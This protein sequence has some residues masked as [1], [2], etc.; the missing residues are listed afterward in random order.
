[1]VAG[2]NDELAAEP[3]IRKLVEKLNTQKN[4]SVD[5][6]VF[7]GADHIF[8]NHADAVSE[9]LEDHVTKKIAAKSAAMALAAD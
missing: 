6:R 1:M 5:Y 8:A 2:D 4:V 9:A 7:A 3:A